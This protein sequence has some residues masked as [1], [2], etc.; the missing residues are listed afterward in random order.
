MLYPLASRIASPFAALGRTV[1]DTARFAVGCHMRYSAPDGALRLR[2]LT[3][4]KVVLGGLVA[5]LYHALGIPF[6][7][8]P[9]VSL[10]FLFVGAYCLYAGHLLAG[11]LMSGC[12]IVNDLADGLATELAVRDLPVKP[13]GRMRLRRMLDTYLVD[14]VARFALYV[15]FVLRLNEGQQVHPMLL[16][17][18]TLIEIASAMLSSAAE[19]GAGRKLE[20]HYEFVLDPAIAERQ[21]GR[22]YLSKV[23]LGQA[24]AYHNYALLPLLGYVVPLSDAPGLYFAIVLAVRLGALLVRLAQARAEAGAVSPAPAQAAPRLA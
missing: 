9:L 23:L 16:M 18:L 15:V 1:R 12:F 6:E 10:P 5:R 8:T 13:T 14:V 19:Q 4:P 17:L 22:G 3:Y 2:A 11:V 7:Y 20:F 21:F 24:T